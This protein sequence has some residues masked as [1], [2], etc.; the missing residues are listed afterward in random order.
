M[1][2]S[3]WEG[4]YTILALL[5]LVVVVS[6]LVCRVEK[7]VVLGLCVG[8]ALVAVFTGVI[9]SWFWAIVIIA[10]I[11]GLVR[12]QLFHDRAVNKWTNGRPDNEL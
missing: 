1:P 12:L 7:S 3:F 4:W 9:E 5:A 11:I 2:A 10:I 6:A 8:F